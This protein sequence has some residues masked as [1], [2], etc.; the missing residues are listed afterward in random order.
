MHG[1]VVTEPCVLGQYA[2]LNSFSFCFAIT[3]GLCTLFFD[4][5]QNVP[6]R[7]LCGSLVLLVN[8]VSLQICI[9]LYPRTALF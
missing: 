6:P 8:A 2:Q 1:W 5:K 9:T 7:L 3:Y 4:I